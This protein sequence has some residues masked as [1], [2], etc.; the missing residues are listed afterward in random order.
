MGLGGVE[1]KD[2]ILHSST[3]L[4]GYTCNRALNR[5]VDGQCT[6]FRCMHYNLHALYFRPL[7]RAEACGSRVVKLLVQL[8]V[9]LGLQ[10]PEE[11]GLGTSGPA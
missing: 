3:V 10:I 1:R 2:L 6:G 9:C 4:L 8:Q 5:V 11:W 7:Q